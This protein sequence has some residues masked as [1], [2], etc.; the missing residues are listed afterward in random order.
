MNMCRDQRAFLSSVCSL[1]FIALFKVYFCCFKL[2]THAHM[3]ACA[4]ESVC[5]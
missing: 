4:Y 5:V 2:C 1:D 3:H